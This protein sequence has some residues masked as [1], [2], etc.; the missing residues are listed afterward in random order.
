MS[1]RSGKKYT[2]DYAKDTMDRPK[3]TEQETD[4]NLQAERKS[5]LQVSDVASQSSK[6]S[7]RSSQRSSRTSVSTAS[8]AVKARAKAKAAQAQLAYAEKEASVIKQKADLE[9][10]VLKQK[11]DLEASL[12]ILQSQRVAAAAEAEATAYEEEEIE[13]GEKLKE[14]HTT[15]EPL[16]PIEQT[17]NYIEQHAELFRDTLPPERGPDSTEATITRQR[18]RYPKLEK[19]EFK[20]EKPSKWDQPLTHLDRTQQPHQSDRGFV[21]EPQGAHDLAKYLMRREF[22]SSGLLKFDD[23]PEH[24]WSWKA[25]FRGA[26]QDLNLSPREELDLMV[27][28]LGLDSSQQA[29]RI[30]SVHVLNPAAGLNMVWQRLEE[31]YGMPEVIENALF[32]KLESFPKLTNKDNDKLRELGDI[33]LELEC[34]KVEG[35]LPGLTYLDT[36]RGVNPIVEKLP[37]SLQEKWIT[38]ASKY[39]EDYEVPFPPF[40]FFSQF[41]R[42]QA[43]NPADHATRF[44]A[45]E[46]LQQTNWFTGPS[47]LKSDSAEKPPETNNFNLV[48]P[49]TDVEIRPIV[50]VLTTRTSSGQ[51]GSHRFERFSDWTRLCNTIARLMSVAVS[52]KKNH[53]DAERETGKRFAKIPSTVELKK[54]E[55]LII[56]DIQQEAFKEELKCLEKGAT[57]PKQSPLQKLSPVKDS[58][59]L[60]R[61]GGRISSAEMSN[62]EKHPLIIPRTCHIATLLVRFFHKEVAHQG[63]HITEGALRAAGYWII[64]AKRLVSS[65]IHKCVICRKLRGH[66]QKQKMADLPRDR[67]TPEPPFTNV[68]LDIFGPWTISTRRTR[69]GSANSKRWAV[70]FTCMSTRAVHIELVESMSTDSFINALRRFFAIRGPAKLLR[71]D[72]GT[73]FVGACRELNIISKEAVIESYLQSKGCTWIFNPPHSSHMGGSWERLIGVARRILDALLLQTGHTHL[74]HEVLSTLMAE[75]MAIMN[76]RPLVPVSNDPEMPTILTPAMLLTQKSSTVSAPSGQFKMGDLQGKQWKHVQCLADTFWKR[77]KQE[78]LSTLQVRRKWTRLEKNIKVGDV[79]LLK[80][81]QAHRNDWPIGIIVKTLPSSDKIVRKVEVKTT[82]GGQVKVFHRPVSEVIVLLSEGL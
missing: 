81:N 39:K 9:A 24:Y 59:D 53:E 10:S 2:K 61:V 26:T 73:N 68:G 79:V 60:L 65:V 50:T 6:R 18:Y 44:T 69:G 40:S 22:V 46:Y 13:S 66:L 37:H 80:D 62:E 8:S 41:V 42:K 45:A 43:K 3:S 48:E 17:S 64:G 20:R 74:T 67:L 77:W 25:S 31:C 28:W 4:A 23:R 56:H 15:E 51:L 38:Q 47:F 72:R 52:F 7:S 75:V 11:A 33:L 16:S 14:L 78:Y 54:A 34:A 63:R 32:K 5:P 57:L 12:H 82:K 29:M 19:I 27:K 1:L 21:P 58:N 49:E 71:S 70:L 76:A 55:I 36:A 35:Y 30:R